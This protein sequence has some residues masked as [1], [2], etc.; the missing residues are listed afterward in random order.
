M[1]FVCAILLSASQVSFGESNNARSPIPLPSPFTPVVDYAHVID[2]EIRKQ[3]ES[4]Y[5]NLKQ[6]ADTEFAV[7]T[8]DTTGDQDIFDY[9]LAVARGWGI[10]SKGG[11]K[12]GFLLLVAIKDRKYFTQVSDHLE[13][14]LNDGLAGEIQRERLV[15][16][17]RRGNY[18][19]GIYDTIQAY[20]ATLAEKRGFSIEGID[21]RYAYRKAPPER[22]TG[23]RTG[24]FSSSCWTLAIILFVVVLLL[25]SMKRGGRGGGC[26]NLF[27]LGSL[28][29]S[30]RGGGGWGGSSSG[31]GGGGFGGGG[32][33]FGGGFGGGGSFGGGGAGG[34]W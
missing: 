7:V 1:V 23:S 11:E 34:G 28:L 8:V 6:R 30:G 18:G 14:D 15:P 22:S 19:Q 13:G 24:G 21:Q 16:Q 9:S 27:L 5:V 25:S 10:G 4:I 2:P 12:A 3:L 32:G 26:L 33:G 17:F 29:N 20:V 31:W